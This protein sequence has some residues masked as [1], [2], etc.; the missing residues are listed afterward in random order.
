MTEHEARLMEQIFN[1]Y[2]EP[3]NQSELND[4][5]AHWEVIE[6]ELAKS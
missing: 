1:P 3:V 5:D 4:V 6:K 2:N